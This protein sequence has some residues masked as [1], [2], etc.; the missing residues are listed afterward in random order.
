MLDVLH[1]HLPHILAADFT[2]PY[3]T[4]NFSVPSGTATFDVFHQSGGSTSVFTVAGGAS[5]GGT[6]S[7]G[8]SLTQAQKD[9]LIAI[10]QMLENINNVTGKFYG[11]LLLYRFL[12]L[13]KRSV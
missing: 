9:N 3:G 4:C 13:I 2:C 5:G 1:I 11:P 10:K 7:G 12:S 6:S 8:L